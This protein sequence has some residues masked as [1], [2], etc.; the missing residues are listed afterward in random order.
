MTEELTPKHYG[1]LLDNLKQGIAKRL[2]GEAEGEPLADWED[3]AEEREHQQTIQQL[4]DQFE[5]EK[6]ALEQACTA[7]ENEAKAEFDTESL[8][9]EQAKTTGIREVNKKYETDAAEEIQNYEDNR[10]VTTSVLDDSSDNPKKLYENFKSQI[11]SGKDQQQIEWK[12]METAYNEGIELMKKRRMWRDFSSSSQ[13]AKPEDRIDA[14]EFFEKGINGARQQIAKIRNHFLPGLFGG[15]MPLLLFA[16]LFGIL[17]AIIYFAIDPQLIGAK[18]VEKKQTWV[19]LS[20]GIAFGG[21]FVVMI[22]LYGTAS[23]MA[24]KVWDA[25]QQNMTNAKH[26]HQHWLKMSKMELEHRKKDLQEKHLAAT[27]QLK[28]SLAEYD[29]NHKK[30]MDVINAA[31]ETGMQ[32]ANENYPALIAQLTQQRDQKIQNAQQQRDQLVAERTK[33]FEEKRDSIVNQRNALL[34][35]RQKAERAHWENVKKEWDKNILTAQQQS[36]LTTMQSL[37][38]FLP[39]DDLSDTSWKS[40]YNIPTSVRLG[41]YAL[42]LAQIENGISTEERLQIDLTRFPFPAVVPFPETPSLLLKTSGDGRN[43]AVK[44]LQVA[45]LR[46]L[47]LLPA[48]KVR[49]TLFDPI[50]LGENFSA[51]MHLGD[52]DEL[53]ISNRI[54]TESSQFDQKL[55]DLTKHMENIFQKYLRNE[56]A[57][58]EEYNAFAGEVA[59]PYHILVIANFPSGFSESAAKRIKSIASSGSRCGVYTLMSVDTK[60][61]MTH[62]FDIADLEQ[63]ANVFEWKK[64]MFR[65]TDPQLKE[66]PLQFDAPPPPEQFNNIV[67]NVG[68][69]SKDMRRVEV[70]FTRIAPKKEEELWSLSAA[71]GIDCPLGRAGAMKLQH[72]KLG[73]GTSQHVLIAGKTGSGKSTFLHA[74]ITNIALYYSPNEVQFFLIDFK[75][76]V[77]FKTYATANMPHASV[78]AIESDREFG[79]SALQKLDHIMKDRGDL[80]RDT[81]VQDLPGFRKARPD[82]PMPRILLVIDEFQEFFVEDDKISQAASQ[83][84]DRLVRQGRAFGIH[85]ILGSQTLGGAYSLPRS[86]LGQI[87]IRVALQCSESDAHLILSEDNSAARLLTRPGEAIY[88]DA[89]GMV[90][91]NNPF[92]VAWLDDDERDAYL[93][94]INQLAIEQNITIEIP[95][96][97]E[98]NIPS[99]PRKNDALVAAIASTAQRRKAAERPGATFVPHAWLGEAVAI[100][101]PTVAEF[102]RQSAKNLIIVGESSEAALGLVS[103]TLISLA[104]QYPLLNVATGTST[105]TTLDAPS[106]PESSTEEPAFGSGRKFE[107]EEFGTSSSG[108]DDVDDGA[109]GSTN[110]PLTDGTN[111]QFYLLNGTPADSLEQPIIEELIQAVGHPV[112]T[113]GVKDA[114]TPLEKI[115]GEVKRRQQEGGDSDPPIFLFVFNLARFRDLRKGDDDFS[116]G[117]SDKNAKQTASQMLQT[118]IADGPE[119]G[120]HVIIWCDSYN[121]LDRWLSRQT[122]R[123][124][125]MRI[126][127][128][129]NANDSSNYIDSPAASKLGPNRAILF[130]EEKGTVEKLRPYAKPDAQWL[131][132]VKE[133]F[134]GS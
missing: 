103:T 56:F 65:S 95:I 85:V 50:G 15:V 34:T 70:S 100:K 14:E 5:Q 75:K 132:W 6:T 73:K 74:L 111:A 82:Q 108:W 49:F 131:N 126:A 43:E 42:D 26:A 40:S 76:G 109:T 102:R 3:A 24:G 80:F 91:G 53:M 52:Y 20:G 89:N 44:T 12:E 107:M 57:T 22:I 125:E 23:S 133:Q 51:F 69:A 55:V 11:L 79:V 63:Y 62:G 105:T 27:K 17:F 33:Q 86:T 119:N 25:L 1:R 47:T 71:A 98:G 58:I 112:A 118:I 21:C 66:L 78:I 81:G 68:E 116:F 64:G 83:L 120:I 39:W 134:T 128:Q 110:Q 90:E 130:L 129:M 101:D 121:N 99:D 77:E 7:A 67:K 9:A 106:T 29:A 31:R 10:W 123:E 8:L 18:S 104:S 28:Q 87:A 113:Y 114:E 97:Y 45:M 4:T 96:V 46:L 38:Q 72:L 19:M 2:Q 32:A 127:F 13:P 60:A 61:K 54:W 48:G 88:N 84:F 93:E 36:E 92:Q 122:M 30:K 41:E 94:T 16:G 35:D 115:A 117:G 37:Q 124:I 59:E